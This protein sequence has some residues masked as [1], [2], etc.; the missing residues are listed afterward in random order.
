MCQREICA[1]AERC[2]EVSNH[3]AITSRRFT[4][5]HL[6]LHVEPVV[7]PIAN[8]VIVQRFAGRAFD[9]FADDLFRLLL[10]QRVVLRVVFRTLDRKTDFPCFRPF[11]S[12]GLKRTV[13]ALL[14]FKRFD[15]D[16]R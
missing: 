1:A 7:Q 16:L 11:V 8:L 5:S 2:D 6:L 13:F 9:N 4:R 12:G 15:C 10:C 3:L 14:P